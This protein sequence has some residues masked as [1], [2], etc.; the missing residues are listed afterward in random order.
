MGELLNNGDVI[1][2]HCLDNAAVLPMVNRALA[3]TSILDGLIY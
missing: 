2:E 1:T 3:V